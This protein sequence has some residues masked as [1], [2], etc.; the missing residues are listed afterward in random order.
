MIYKV[1]TMIAM[2]LAVAAG[3]PVEKRLAL[4]EAK[5]DKVHDAM[6]A[7][8]AFDLDEDEEGDVDEQAR[9]GE[10]AGCD[11]PPA[12]LPHAPPHADVRASHACVR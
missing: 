10:R 5:V 3:M 12:A 8:K 6:L 4:L 7:A 9:A 11:E 1:L 2:M